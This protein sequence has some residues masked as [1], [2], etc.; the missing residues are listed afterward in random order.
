MSGNKPGLRE[1]PL[2]MPKGSVRALLALIL[3]T[4]LVYCMITKTP[5]PGEIYALAGMVV[6]AYYGKNKE[7]LEK[8]LEKMINKGAR[9]VKKSR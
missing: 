7:D 1:Q 8:M 2:F 4:S 6:N 5:V 3:I 9:D